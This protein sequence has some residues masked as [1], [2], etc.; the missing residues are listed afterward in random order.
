[1]RARRFTVLLVVVAIVACAPQG[2]HQSTE[3]AAMSDRW[4]EA[5]NAGDAGAVAAFYTE[6]CRLL[7]PNAEMAQGRAAA[8]VAFGE[9]VNDGL[10]VGL[11]TVEAVAAGDIG[12]RLGTYWLQTP[13][14]TVVDQGKFIETWKKEGGEWKIANDIWNSDWAP[15]ANLTTVLITLDVKDA[16]HWIGAFQGPDSRKELFAKHGVANVRVFQNPEKVKSVALLVDA[17]DLDAFQAFVA[18]PESTTAK[19]EDGV[20]EASLRILEEVN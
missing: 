4:V 9:M 7:P 14:G 18:S 13:D 5:F 8:E 15:G 6:D 19:A 3:I 16:A 17:A 10:M 20:I 1:M 12:H 2:S 11:D